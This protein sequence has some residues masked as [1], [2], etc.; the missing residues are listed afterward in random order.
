MLSIKV[1]LAPDES[2]KVIGRTLECVRQILG[3]EVP[4]VT[5]DRVHLAKSALYATIE[6]MGAMIERLAYLQRLFREVLSL[7]A[8]NGDLRE[9]ER[10]VGLQIL[11]ELSEKLDQLTK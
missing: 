7:L 11:S 2:L 6:R 1:V 10:K 9:Y 3:Q 8:L 5:N 4:M